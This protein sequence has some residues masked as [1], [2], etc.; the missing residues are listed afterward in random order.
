MVRA[1]RTIDAFFAVLAEA[2]RNLHV[3]GEW[4]P[5]LQSEVL[6]E[7]VIH[8]LK[9]VS[10]DL[11]RTTANVEFD[12]LTHDADCGLRRRSPREDAPF[13][14]QA[15][16]PEERMVDPGHVSRAAEF[17]QWRVVDLTNGVPSEVLD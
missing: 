4:L 7:K 12:G 17:A 14:V 5:L 9:Q 11:P 15:T 6:Y 10:I 2:G 3:A 1:K 16:Q 8:C 13:L